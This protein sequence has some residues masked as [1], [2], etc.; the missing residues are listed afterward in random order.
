MSVGCG[1]IAEKLECETKGLRVRQ[2]GDQ[3]R[4]AV[5]PLRDALVKLGDNAPALS[6]KM[7]TA[8]DFIREQITVKD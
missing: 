3:R 4:V 5:H 8:Y 6:Q 7:V 2:G 1:W